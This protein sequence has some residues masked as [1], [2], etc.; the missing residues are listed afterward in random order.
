MK[1]NKNKNKNT[2]KFTKYKWLKDK[3]RQKKEFYLAT[4]TSACNVLTAIVNASVVLKQ[5]SWKTKP[6]EI[7]PFIQGLILLW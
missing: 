1:T 2:T 5:Y 3:D 4:V 7:T 6:F